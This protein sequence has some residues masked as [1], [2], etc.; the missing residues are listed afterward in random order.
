MRVNEHGN[1]LEVLTKLQ[2]K[3]CFVKEMTASMVRPL[4][5]QGKILCRHKIPCQLERC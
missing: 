3:M 5:S 4:D 2:G 1:L